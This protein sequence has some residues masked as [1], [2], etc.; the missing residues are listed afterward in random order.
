M[1]VFCEVIYLRFTLPFIHLEKGD[2]L[3]KSYRNNQN[4]NCVSQI[5]FYYENPVKCEQDKPCS[6]NE[7]CGFNYEANEFG[8]CIGKGCDCKNDGDEPT[9]WECNPET[10]CYTHQECGYDGNGICIQGKMT[11]FLTCKKY[12]IHISIM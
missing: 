10:R 9:P 3:V 11:N 7:E 8:T 1:K 4:G 12:I 6:I 5:F 2:Y